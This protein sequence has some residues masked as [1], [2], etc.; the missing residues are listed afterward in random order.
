[1][2]P[3]TREISLSIAAAATLILSLAACS[4]TPSPSAAPSASASDTA[5]DGTGTPD[6][7]SCA[8]VTV[9]VDTGDLEVD[10]DPSAT[11]CVDTDKAISGSEAAEK[12]GIA[13]VG[14][15]TYP[16]DVTCRVNGVPSEETELP[17]ADGAAYHETCADMPAATAY[18]SLWVK[19]ADGEWDYA[20]TGL[21]GLEL[22]PGD[23][24]EL[25]FTLNGSPA[26]PAS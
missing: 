15:V 11:T 10:D 24:V 14:T 23:S 16:D 12:A 18:W 20:Q 19:P 25:L 2:I 5:T 7:D 9:I 4:P 26:S 1:M 3:K 21:S 6:G 22:N 17:G 13:T 8:G